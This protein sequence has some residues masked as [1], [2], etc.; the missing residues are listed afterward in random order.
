MCV[1]SLLVRKTKKA[2]DLHFII[3]NKLVLTRI[4]QVMKDGTSNLDDAFAQF[5]PE[6]FVSPWI[7][8]NS[9]I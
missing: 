4:K 5:E 1:F 9:K 8:E 6:N 3:T 2:R 7:L